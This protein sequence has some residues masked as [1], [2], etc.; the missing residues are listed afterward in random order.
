VPDARMKKILTEAVTVDKA[1][2][3]AIVFKTRMKDAYFYPNGAWC[4]PFIGGSYKFPLQLGMR[5]SNDGV[6]WRPLRA[7]PTKSDTFVIARIHVSTSH[8]QRSIS[9]SNR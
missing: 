8:S 7:S 3:R 1:T 2:A 5:K 6:R 9:N 4:T